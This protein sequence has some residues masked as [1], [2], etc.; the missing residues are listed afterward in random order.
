MADLGFLTGE[1][2]PQS[3]IGYFQ[4]SKLTHHLTFYSP[5]PQQSLRQ[6]RPFVNDNEVNSHKS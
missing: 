5:K 2:C 3:I 1:G 6:W 4:A